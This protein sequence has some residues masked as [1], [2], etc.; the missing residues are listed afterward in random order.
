MSS[1]VPVPVDYK[2]ITVSSV[3]AYIN[4]YV[5]PKRITDFCCGNISEYKIYS[6]LGSG[7]YSLVYLG[8]SPYGLCAIKTLRQIEKHRVMREV[9]IMKQLINVQHVAKFFDLVND[10]LTD[11]YSII[12]QFYPF[13]PF[14]EL[15]LRVT[16]NEIRN[17]IHML[18][19]TLDKIHQ[20][21]I[22]HRDIKPGNVLMNLEE[23]CLAIIDWGLAD[24]YFP[25]KQSSVK[26]ATL[27]Y[28]PPELLLSYHYYDYGIDIWGCGCIMAEL[29]IRSTFFDGET[30]ED[31]LQS[32]SSVCGSL[33][34]INYAEKFGLSLPNSIQLMKKEDT[35]LTLQ[36]NISPTKRNEKAIDL[37]KKLLTI[38]H[39]N[40][41]TARDALKHPY[42]A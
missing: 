32:L 36:K 21:G 42:F 16:N 14:N 7:K 30:P 5:S 26:V 4:E 19:E 29:M 12:T 20:K 40:R 28:K 1:F 10:G 41:I 38:D 22:M 2:I 6:P 31:V 27:R 9:S 35:W 33:S 17:L 13:T 34:L 3:Y 11:T 18:L 8:T 15:F 37:L 25:W 23:N 24:Y 39:T